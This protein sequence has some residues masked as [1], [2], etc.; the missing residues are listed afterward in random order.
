MTP[1]RRR[2]GLLRCVSCNP[3][4]ARPAGRDIDAATDGD[5][6]WAAA[7]IPTARTSSTPRASSPTTAA[8]LL[9]ELRRARPRATPTASR[10]SMSG[11]RRA[12]AT[13]PPTAPGY[14][15]ALGRLR[16]P[17]L[18][19]REPAGLRIRRR[20]RRRPRRLLHDR[21]EPGAPGPRPGRHLRRPRRRRL[22]A[23]AAP[24]GRMRR[25]SL[26]D[27]PTAAERP[28]PL[29]RQLRSARGNPV[30][31]PPKCP[32]GKHKVKNKNGKTR[33]RQEQGQEERSKGKANKNGRAAR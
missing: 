5:P 8:P 21:G 6:F 16:Q 33:L 20:Q 12:P 25:R 24:A 4:G 22:P 32:K 23:G 26:P 19:R 15:Q 13:A 31:K 17:D 18:H 2:S 27:P 9:R 3:S 28:D 1:K 29:Q 10:T 7:Q 11:R 14:Q 30:N